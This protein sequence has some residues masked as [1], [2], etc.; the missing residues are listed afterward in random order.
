MTAIVATHGMYIS[1][2]AMNASP[3][4]GVNISETASLRPASSPTPVRRPKV[5]T[6]ISFARKPKNRAATH[7]QS[8]PSGLKMGSKA[9]PSM[10]M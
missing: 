5:S 4:T 1:V 9:L 6:T 3:L 2:K 8:N 10:A 7:L